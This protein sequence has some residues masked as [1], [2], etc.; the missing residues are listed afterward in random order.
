MYFVAIQNP[1]YFTRGSGETWLGISVVQ[2]EHKS[3]PAA[4]FEPLS[5]ALG[6]WAARSQE[7]ST[8]LLQDLDDI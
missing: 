6:L 1:S 8:S 2:T 3:A 5:V 7:P 4:G